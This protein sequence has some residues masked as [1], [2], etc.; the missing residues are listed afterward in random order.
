[1]SDDKPQ[2]SALAY[3]L[4]SGM[5]HQP[6]LLRAVAWLLRR[7]G[8]LS[9]ALSAV[10][11]ADGV[12]R[13][14]AREAAF[15][16]DR[17]APLLVDGPFLIGLP[18]GPAHDAKR[19][20]LHRLLPEPADVASGSVTALAGIRAN[21][22]ARMAADG[23]FDLIDDY[24]VPLVWR[25]IALAYGAPAA[26]ALEARPGLLEAARW[27]GAQL[28]IGEVAPA[29]ERQRALRSKAI[30]D[31][32]FGHAMGVAATD[33]RPEWAASIPGFLERRRDAIGLLWVG[34]PATTQGGALNLQ[35][36][37]GRPALYKFLR[38]EAAQPGNDPSSAAW[39]TALKP[40]VLELLRFRPPFPLLA[41]TVPRE[42]SYPLGEGQV[43]TA[44]PGT[45]NVLTIGAL[46]DP[47]GQTPSPRQYAPLRHFAVEAD[48]WLIFGAGPRHCIAQDQVVEILVTALAGLLSLGPK[49]LRY[50]GKPWRRRVYDG[51]VIV[52]MPLRF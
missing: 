30:L 6:L 41:R 9:S 40:H 19:A 51:P 48:R 52:K 45:L 49:P 29:A 20:C 10:A 15:T 5:L 32:A 14:L 38:R 35:E 23:Q 44:R 18:S 39:R 28:L 13:A 43:A 25:S 26:Q 3:R 47:A 8:F 7:F 27:L 50:A 46:F 21:V 33:L 12:R 36:L 34:H 24:L 42:A 31:Q 22:Q 1:M 11:S 4:V 2:G 37:L 17:Y 16:H